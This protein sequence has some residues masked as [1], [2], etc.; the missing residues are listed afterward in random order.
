MNGSRRKFDALCIMIILIVKKCNGITGN[1]DVN[2]LFCF[3]NDKK[4]FN[5]IFMVVVNLLS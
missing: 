3:V 2:N 4:Y 1:E 5:Y